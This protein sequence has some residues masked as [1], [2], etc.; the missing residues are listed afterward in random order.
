[1]AYLIKEDVKNV[2]LLL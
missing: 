1:V 2:L